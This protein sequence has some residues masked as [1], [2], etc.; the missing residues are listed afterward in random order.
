MPRK[1]QF[2]VAF[3]G[4]EAV[5]VSS[6]WIARQVALFL[7]T[8]EAPQLIALDFRNADSANPILKKAFAFFANER[9]Q[10][11]NRCVVN[12][13]DALHCVD[14]ASLDKELNNF[15]SFVERSVHPSKWCVALFR[16]S[17]AALTATE[18]LQSVP[19]LPKF[20]AFGLA[21]VA[22][23]GLRPSCFLRGEALDSSFRFESGLRPL[24]NLAPAK[25]RTFVGALSYLFTTKPKW[26]SPLTADDSSLFGESLNAGIDKCQWIVNAL[27]VVA[28]TYQLIADF[29]GSH[30]SPRIFVE[31]R[32]N[33]ISPCD[34]RLNLLAQGV[35]KAYFRGLHLGDF[36]IQLGA[37]PFFVFDL[38]LNLTE[39]VLE[40]L[41]HGNTNYALLEHSCQALF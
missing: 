35:L 31:S 3:N 16:E 40:C 34:F 33:K 37:F 24:L 9:Q 22:R 20:F 13:S 36:G 8:N 32:Q 30:R 27:E 1:N 7:T 19:M 26:S 5:S 23:H 17:L 2:C 29:D 10:R 21:V 38:F 15:H 11:E 39:G 12:A 28:P 14:G 41:C 6:F 18:T 4:D 25:A